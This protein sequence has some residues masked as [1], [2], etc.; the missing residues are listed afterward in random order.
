ML[1]IFT[2]TYNRAH[3]LKILYESLKDQS[4]KNFEWLIIDDGSTDKTQDM[5]VRWKD[6]DNG[7]ILRYYVQQ[8]GG[9]H[10]AINKG[11]ELAKG[12]FF[13]IVDSDDYI[14]SSA[15]Q[16]ING[17]IKDIEYDEHFAGVS[18]GLAT[19]QSDTIEACERYIDATNLERKKRGLLGDKAEI[20]K[21]NVLRQYPFPEYEN[22]YFI[23][24]AV[25]W[26]AIAAKGLKI[27]W[28]SDII[29]IANYR[30][31][32]LTKQ[33]ANEV[34]GAINNYKGFCYYVKQALKLYDIKDKCKIMLKFKIVADR[35]KIKMSDRAE[36]LNISL[37]EIYI[38]Y[39]ISWML[40][41]LLN[42]KFEKENR[43]E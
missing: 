42:I 31:D 40:C 24:E 13:F 43:S 37:L 26:D 32:G 15:V 19:D 3:T 14:V 27:R 25:C 9:K 17:W 38:W 2:P 10:R 5:L 30:E 36:N 39:I 35:K 7:F 12:T 8:H 18:G 11:V 34:T 33:G 6:E 16:K 23:T 29:Y 21:V 1:T 28:F 20:Y 22:E 4:D 41:F